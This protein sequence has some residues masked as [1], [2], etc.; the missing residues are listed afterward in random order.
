[1]IGGGSERGIDLGTVDVMGHP[2]I[3][4]V[5]RPSVRLLCQARRSPVRH[6]RHLGGRRVFFSSLALKGGDG[7]QAVPCHAY[8]R[9]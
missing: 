6:G 7:R 2:L 9:E 4:V 1:M 8:I 3:V 5:I